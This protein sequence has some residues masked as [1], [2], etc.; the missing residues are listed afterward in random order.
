M[1]FDPILFFSGW[2]V[3]IIVI[4]DAL[5]TTMGEGGGFIT[6]GF[7]ASLNKVLSKIKLIYSSHR[8]MSYAGIGTTILAVLLWIV[9]LMAGWMLIFSSNEYSVI[10]SL[11]YSY[12]GFYDRL[13]YVG[14]TMLTLGNGDFKPNGP[15]WQMITVIASLSGLFTITFSIT[16]LV[17][18]VQAFT[19]KRS[20]AVLLTHLG[21]SPQ[22]ILENT[23]NGEDFN[24][25]YEKCD[26]IILNLAQLEQRHKTYPVLH[27][28]HSINRKEVLSIGLARLDEA[29]TI[30]LFG[31]DNVKKGK[32]E[33]IRK[34]ISDL[35]HTLQDA[36]IHA[37]DETPPLPDLKKINLPGVKIKSNDEFKERAKIAE[38]HRRL[39]K[40]FVINERRNWDE[41]YNEK[42]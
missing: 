25:L 24:D 1:P 42:G 23:W 35:L 34:I 2:V 29:I 27:Y 32:L 15:L 38:S 40:A 6:K 18:V 22:N 14:Y 36:F 5:W 37:A 30:L 39:L 8:L 28:L 21:K 16:Y 12:A 11:N 41:V 19:D 7:T 4:L 10:D 17:P 33:L 26:K 31:V 20:L 9:L 13:Y 3:I